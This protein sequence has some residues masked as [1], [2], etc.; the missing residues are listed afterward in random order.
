MRRSTKIL[1]VFVMVFYV[2]S[3][4]PLSYSLDA[5]SLAK[6]STLSPELR[7][8]PIINRDLEYK[9]MLESFVL[10]KFNEKPGYFL[11]LAQNIRSNKNASSIFTD[12]A[13]SK[14]LFLNVTVNND[15]IFFEVKLNGELYHMYLTGYKTEKISILVQS[16]NEFTEESV[17]S[18]DSDFYVLDDTSDSYNLGLDFFNRI[19]A[20]NLSKNL[21]L[22]MHQRAIFAANGVVFTYGKESLVIDK[23]KS[24]EHM[25]WSI[26]D[27]ITHSIDSGTFTLIWK[28]LRKAFYDFASE[29]DTFS[30]NRYPVLNEVIMQIEH[31]LVKS[32]NEGYMSFDN[33]TYKKVLDSG[34][35]DSR[36]RQ[37]IKEKIR[38][39]FNEIAIKETQIYGRYF[40]EFK[41]L[42]VSVPGSNS[43]LNFKKISERILPVAQANANGT[44]TI[45]EK[46]VDVMAYLYYEEFKSN[47]GNA[48]CDFYGAE[49]WTK[50][51]S[52]FDSI[53]YSVAIHEIRG[54]FKYENNRFMFN[55]DEKFAQGQ[56]GLGH[57]YPNVLS[58]MYFWFAICEFGYNMYEDRIN[59][60]MEEYPELF[61]LLSREEKEHLAQDLIRI[62]D[63]FFEDS[64]DNKWFTSV[65]IPEPG[66]VLLYLRKATRSMTVK[67]LVGKFKESSGGL[68]SQDYLIKSL[69]LLVELGLVEVALSKKDSIGNEK[70]RAVTMTTNNFIDIE[71]IFEENI[72]DPVKLKSDIFSKVLEEGEN[73]WATTLIN[74]VK[75]VNKI[76][77]DSDSEKLVLIY[78]NNWVPKGQRNLKVFQKLEGSILKMIEKEGNVDVVK[79]SSSSGVIDEIRKKKDVPLKNFIVVADNKVFLDPEIAIMLPRDKHD[80]D[81][82]FCVAVDG[83]NLSD[84]T[85]IQL[86]EIFN[87]VFKAFIGRHIYKGHPGIEQVARVVG[88]YYLLIP[89]GQELGIEKIH[90]IYMK[91]TS[92]IRYA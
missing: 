3:Q 64:L 58:M 26:V 49:K 14:I 2:F 59:L 11:E 25:A 77:L 23:N 60:F 70:Y 8:K 48:L 51:L 83:E 62:H 32:S 86:V 42:P 38:C 7:Y 34:K 53:I 63:N 71:N 82:L 61:V 36:T 78:D 90:D 24:K 43:K 46:F 45:N 27:Q 40:K 66:I 52:L 72:K 47:R 44:I 50:S 41:I 5:V 30:I 76:K 92:F 55:P 28:D 18:D 9:N 91:Q 33:V 39:I 35:V 12:F 57:V 85:Y 69:N 65:A 88:K 84:E 22:K 13:G 20:H 15:F 80:K 89:M 31:D 21:K 10:Y 16:S 68:S 19:G 4:I 73:F 74:L 56:R 1:S 29:K 75:Q 17:D 6:R 81:R 54:H 79:V 67:E 37:L 87:M